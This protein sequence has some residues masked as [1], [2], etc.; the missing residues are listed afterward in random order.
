[1]KV[2]I[3]SDT[4]GL[5]MNF[6]TVLEKVRPVDCL[7]HCGDV[8][9]DDEYISVVAGC[10]VHIVAGNNDWGSMLDREIITYIGPYRVMI[11]HGHT[12]SVNYGMERLTEIAKVKGVDI[13]MFGHTHIPVIEER[14]GIV[15]INPGSL[16]LPRQYGRVPTYAMMNIDEND[17]AHF[18]IIS[19]EKSGVKMLQTLDF[20]GK[21]K[22]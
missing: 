5:T 6:D 11:T 22:K 20:K 2:L 21:I 15:Y 8:E 16:T 14:D 7:V 19:L 17:V 4:H 1:M 9:R 10:P 18:S 12:Y 3:V 13:V